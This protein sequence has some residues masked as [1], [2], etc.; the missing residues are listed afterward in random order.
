[1]CL[2]LQTNARIKGL[3]TDILSARCLCRRITTR[4]G[5]CA[6]LKQNTC[7]YERVIDNGQDVTMQRLKLEINS[8][9]HSFHRRIE[10][11]NLRHVFVTITDKSRPRA[12]YCPFVTH[13]VNVKSIT[14]L[15]VPYNLRFICES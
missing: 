7:L 6:T 1:M 4:V 3:T 13:R 10:F 11:W 8:D 15:N 2:R 14:P 12:V 9:K 5:C